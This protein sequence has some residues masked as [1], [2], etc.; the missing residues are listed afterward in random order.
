MSN[1]RASLLTADV[2]GSD[3]VVQTKV[4]ISSNN[5]HIRKGKHQRDFLWHFPQLPPPPIIIVRNSRKK[6]TELS[7]AYIPL[8]KRIGCVGSWI[9]IK[10][11]YTQW[12]GNP[13]KATETPCL[14][15]LTIKWGQHIDF[16]GQATNSRTAWIFL[17]GWS[18]KMWTLLSRS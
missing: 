6:N 12:F 17:I 13:R 7:T 3:I 2:S 15:S 16:K 4:W 18:R 14:A 8:L 1:Y 9:M 11:L 10:V 5:P